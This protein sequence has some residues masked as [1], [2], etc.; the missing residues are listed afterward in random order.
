[1][2]ATNESRFDRIW[3]DTVVDGPPAK[4]RKHGIRREVVGRGTIEV[5]G[6]TFTT[7]A[8]SCQECRREAGGSEQ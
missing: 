1:M 6:R 4:C 8:V 5:N 3:R 2:K 7:R